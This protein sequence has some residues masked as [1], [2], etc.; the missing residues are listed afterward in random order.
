MEAC[1]FCSSFYC[2]PFNMNSRLHPACA[3]S[4]HD[5]SLTSPEKTGPVTPATADAVLIARVIAV[6]RDQY[7]LSS[8]AG[9]FP[10]VLTG[11]FCYQHQ[12]L[13]ADFPCVGDWVG[14]TRADPAALASIDTVLPRKSMLCRKRPGK[15]VDYQMIAANIDTAFVTQS[16]HFDFNLPRLERYLV[17]VREGG[18]EPV[19]LLTKTDL[20]SPETLAQQLAAIHSAGITVPVIPL[21]NID[22]T[23]LAHLQS[24]IQPDKTYCLLGSSGIGKT[25]LINRLQGNTVLVTGSVSH[26][27]EGRHT[28]TRRQL[29]PLAQGGCLI[30]LPGMRELGMLG[31]AE[32]LESSFADIEAHA[33]QC[34]FRNCTHTT[35]PGCAVRAAIEVQA[36]EAG[37]FHN[38]QK[39]HKEAAFH[40]LS[41]LEKRR[42]DRAF[43]KLVNSTLKQKKG[44]HG[45]L[46]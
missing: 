6:D 46:S 34:R 39:L 26:S 16:A 35:E 25:T 32:S 40:D 44:R 7:L 23:G 42:K 31:V 1:G 28:T 14:V 3:L 38:Y 41:Y 11:R 37:H 9:D 5:S 2:I 29:I 36:L 24:L 4:Q 30:D 15:A 27:G 22:G 20:V 10:A 19:I 17:M 33:A 12:A 8:P 18:I 45:K 43:G 13:P 21:S